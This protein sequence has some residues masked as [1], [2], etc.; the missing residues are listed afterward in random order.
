MCAIQ[1]LPNTPAEPGLARIGSWTKAKYTHKCFGA[2]GFAARYLQRL[3]SYDRHTVR[4][5]LLT[6][7]A[8][9]S[10]ARNAG[11]NSVDS[12]FAPDALPQLRSAILR[13]AVEKDRTCAQGKNCESGRRHDAK[14]LGIQ[15]LNIDDCHFSP[16]IN[17]PRVLRNQHIL[18]D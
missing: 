6:G 5:L 7:C 9:I 1:S 4:S 3:E 14:R 8:P 13:L 10:R 12:V 18:P 2:R 11:S 17:I 16:T 15:F